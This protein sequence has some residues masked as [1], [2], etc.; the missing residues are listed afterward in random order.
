MANA[1]YGKAAGWIGFET[2][3]AATLVCAA[4]YYW[5]TGLEPRW[6][7]IWLAALPV[8]WLA[9]RVSAW[10]ALGMAFVARVLGAMN[11]VYYMHHSI[12][13]PVWVVAESV[14]VPSIVFMLAAG[15]YRSFFVR[16]RRWLA[17]LAFPAV[18]VAGEYLTNLSQGTFGDTAY[19]QLGN[20]PVLQ[21]GALAGL[22]GIGFAVLLFPA[23][24]A[25][26]LS[27]RGR[28]RRQLAWGL[29]AFVVCVFGYGAARLYLT[30]RAPRMA[31]VGLIDRDPANMLPSAPEQVMA[32]ADEYSG[33]IRMLAA[34]GAKYV[35]LPEA[36]VLVTRGDVG[37]VDAFFEQTAREAGV[38]VLVGMIDTTGPET[39]NEARLYSA[40][41]TLETIYHKHHLVPGME[42]GAIP[43]GGMSVL[44]EPVGRVGVE[45]CRDMDYPN[46]ARKYGARDVGLMLVPA[47]DFGV[48]RTWH[49]HMALMRGV[50]NGY[51]IVRVAK[52]GLMTV[53]DDR[54]R[55]MA[56]TPVA[57]DGAFTTMLVMVPV[58]HDATLYGGWGDW[59][60]W[61]VLA[62]LAAMLVVWVGLLRRRESAVSNPVMVEG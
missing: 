60:A 50:E 38:Q 39:F 57:A 41:G 47:W 33:E 56:E 6:W 28:E 42:S 40:A 12:H 52:R 61:L 18:I 3:L 37:Q 36:T 25:A 22:Y 31:M 44:D 55:V 59:F 30:P 4:G 35:V 20:L 51:S 54:G 46:P 11:L 45:I 58:R 43:G 21:L 9:P 34:R 23:L 17:V 48:D 32:L 24:G 27:S 8:L 62:G 49:G 53:S 19:T 2:V 1:S 13:I 26:A 15:L 14:A 7:P 5:S 29:G 10:T 16:G